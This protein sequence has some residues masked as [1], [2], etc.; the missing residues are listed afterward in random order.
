MNTDI[1]SAEEFFT[2]EYQRIVRESGGEPIGRQRAIQEAS[3]STKREIELGNV[4]EPELIPTLKL[5]GEGVDSSQGRAADR[6]IGRLASGQV[7]MFD[8]GEVLDMVVTLGG[9]MRKSWR[10]VT[11]SDLADMYETRRQNHDKQVEAFLRFK[12]DYEAVLP[13]VRMFGTVES[14]VSAGAFGAEVAA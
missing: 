2:K 12:E 8:A 10:F 7:S 6:I 9:G 5:M 4:K 14:A 1:P 3:W 11:E 13:V